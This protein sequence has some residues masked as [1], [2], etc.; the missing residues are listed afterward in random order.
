MRFH[1]STISL[2]AK[3]EQKPLFGR[4]LEKLLYMYFYN[5]ITDIFQVTKIK[6][7]LLKSGFRFGSFF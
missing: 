7:I 1:E 6:I 2:M 3:L 5:Y 4:S